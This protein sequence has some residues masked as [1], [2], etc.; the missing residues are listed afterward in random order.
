[1]KPSRIAV[2]VMLLLLLLLSPGFLRRTWAWSGAFWQAR[3]DEV[4]LACGHDGSL[5]F[6]YGIS[7]VGYFTYWAVGGLY[8]LADLGLRPHLLRQYKTQAGTNEP[9][10]G[11]ALIK[12]LAVVN[13]NQLVLGLPFVEACRRILLM[14]GADFSPRLPPF[15]LVLQ[16]LSVFTII[17]EVLFYYF[18]RLCHHRLLYKHIHKLHHEWQSP[19]A[20]TAAYAHPVEHL[21]VNM[22][23][24]MVGPILLGSHPATIWLWVF[25]ATV[26]VL[27]H[28]S[29]Y[30]L[31]FLPSP[32]FHDYHHLKFT[33]CYGVL[34]VLDRLH[35]TDQQFLSTLNHQK[36]HVYFSLQSPMPAAARS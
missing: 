4:L 12:C 5:A 36:D 19:I 29:G 9:V 33:G 27:V 21:F 1:M 32:Q 26:N 3:Y 13:V 15:F 16:H 25:L 23:P 20:V 7:A 11:R 18:H 22:I 30:H 14:R 28:H 6:L 31:P 35:G 8:T 2:L 24:I 10:S 17:E 34:G